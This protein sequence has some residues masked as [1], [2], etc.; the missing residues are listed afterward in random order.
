MADL[1]QSTLA[2]YETMSLPPGTKRI[3]SF[4]ST[5]EADSFRTAIYAVKRKLRD[6][7]VLVSISGKAVTLTKATNAVKITQIDPEGNRVDVSQANTNSDYRNKIEEIL[8]DAEEI[9]EALRAEFIKEAIDN[10]S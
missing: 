9:D 6:N 4:D 3:Y 7:S 8:S 2:F 10:L 1:A 5:K